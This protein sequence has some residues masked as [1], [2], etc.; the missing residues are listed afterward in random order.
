MCKKLIY[1]VVFTLFIETCIGYLAG[2]PKVRA[3]SNVEIV[4]AP[5]G[6]GNVCEVASPCSLEAGR[7]KVRTLNEDMSSDITVL[8]R[9]G[10]YTLNEPFNLLPGDSGQN[11]Y[12][13]YYRAYP[14]ETPILSGGTVISGWTL[15]DATNNIY[16]APVAASLETRQLYVNGQRA[17]RAKGGALPGAQK[18][19]TGYTTTDMSMKEWE[20]IQDIEFVFRKLWT[21]SRCGVSAIVDGEV[22]MDEPCFQM[23]N[24]TRS[25]Q[26]DNPTWIENAYEL[27]DEEGEWYLD[28][29]GHYLYYIPR[30]GEDMT[31]AEVIAPVLES[32]VIGT[33]TL[34]DPL[35]NVVFEGLT[36]SYATWLQPNGEFGF[37]DIQAGFMSPNEPPPIAYSYTDVK[38]PASVS[39]SGGRNLRFER[40]T[41]IHLGSVGLNVD[42][43]AQDNLIQGNIFKDISGNAMMLGD[44]KQEDY[45]PSVEAR[46][47]DRNTIKNNFITKVGA[48]YHGSVGIWTGYTKNTVVAHNEI[49]DLPYSGISIGW[50]WGE[51]DE[52]GSLNYT[53]PTIVEN[54][55]IANNK[56]WNTMHTLVD[57]AGIY[58][59]SADRNQII[60]GNVISDVHT[61]GAIYLDNNSRYNTVTNNVSFD[62]AGSNHLFFN[63]NKGNTLLSYN[64]WD[65]SAKLYD[66]SKNGVFVSNQVVENP[67]VLPASIINNAGLENAFKD[68]NPPTSPTDTEAPSVPGSLS[69]IEG[70]TA[71]L[72][73]SVSLQWQA[74]S[75]NTAVTGYEILR[76]GIVVGVTTATVFTVR[77]LEPGRAYAFSV[78]ARDAALNLSSLTP[79]LLVTTSNQSNLDNLAYNKK[80]VATYESPEGREAE[81]HIDRNPENAVDGDPLTYAA[82]INEYAWQQ[83][84]DLGS[85]QTFNRVVVMMDPG[86]YASEYDIR[87]SNDGI[88]FTT[89]KSVV[90]F[91]GG[92]SEQIISNTEARYV[93]IVALKPD[94]PGQPG[95]QMVIYELEIYNDLA[96]DPNPSEVNMAL[97]KPARAFYIGGDNVTTKTTGYE[98]I[99]D[100]DL[101]TYAQVPR[102]SVWKAAVDLGFATDF[103][104]IKVSMPLTAYASDFKIE[105]SDNGSTYS[106]VSE[107]AEF[108]GGTYT[109]YSSKNA[110][111]VRVAAVAPVNP[112]DGEQMAIAEIGVYNTDNLSIEQTSQALNDDGTSTTMLQ[113]NE[114]VKANDGDFNTSAISAEQD[115]WHWN[116]NLGTI[117][118]INQI[119]LLV[120]AIPETSDYMDIGISTSVNGIDFIDLEE[121]TAFS[122]GWKTIR[123][124]DRNA[125]Y[126]RISLA[127][128]GA[129]PTAGANLSLNEVE[130]YHENVV[131]IDQRTT[132]SSD[133]DR[134]YYQM[135]SSQAYVFQAGDILE[136]EFMLLSDKAGIGGVDIATSDGKRLK[137]QGD[138]VD[139]WHISGNPASDL[140]AQGQNLWLKRTMKVPSSMQGRTASAWRLAMENDQPLTELQV[141]YKNLLVRN[142]F[143]KVALRINMDGSIPVTG[144]FIQGYELDTSVKSVQLNKR[145]VNLLIGATEALVANVVPAYALNKQVVWTS[146]HPDIA[147][148]DQEGVVTAIQAGSAIVTATTADGGYS[149]QAEV[150]V[151]LYTTSSDNYALNKPAKAYTSGG[152]DSTTHS[153]HEPGKANDGSLETVAVSNMV[154]AWN[155][156]VDLEQVRPINFIQGHMHEASYATEFDIVGS[157]NGETYQLLGHYEN[158]NGGH[159]TLRFPT[160][161]YRYVQ[162]RALKPDGPGQKGDLMFLSE[163]EVYKESPIDPTITPIQASFDKNITKAADLEVSL[164][165]NG[166]TLTSIIKEEEGLERNVDYTINGNVVKLKKEY[167]SGLTGSEVQFSFLFSAGPTRIYT[168]SL[169]DSTPITNPEPNSGSETKPITK[170][171]KDENETPLDGEGKTTSETYPTDVNPGHWAALAVRK[172]INLG[173]VN[174]YSDGTFRP[175]SA[176]TRAEFTTML[177]RSLKL[178]GDAGTPAFKDLSAIPVWARDSVAQAVNMGIIN[179]YSDDS[180]RPSNQITRAEMAV[181]IVKAL[182]L[183]VSEPNN[184]Y[185]SDV[186]HIPMWAKPY[187]SAAYA[188]GLL[189]GRENNLFAPQAEAT[190]AEAVFLILSFLE[191][192]E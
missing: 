15:N 135:V 185:F 87:T 7:D 84:V 38:M 114:A 108:E 139:Q 188:V 125:Q 46:A 110:R 105:V 128:T 40:N 25:V 60:S 39:F 92:T 93:R 137:D 24:N 10:T 131:E 96:G 177:I 66:N 69:L 116:L 127:H 155:W 91:S 30:A 18:T 118:N 43:G 68:L 144:E 191:Y 71:I 16:R 121:I 136:Y 99:V 56:I 103:N 70:D 88:N 80:V 178:T 112:L 53:I 154:F 75:D 189:K 35:E 153:G 78:A 163:V 13:I 49:T 58:S 134:Y 120:S 130:V 180:F 50:G 150:K 17:E 72:D 119:R 182:K 83:Q 29:S 111:Y 173:I 23:V 52:G 168:V 21:E 22:T 36:F 129:S 183:P 67:L 143:G 100:D 148:V 41:F 94:G 47:V 85:L 28:R 140:S 102:A 132:N 2:L 117:K 74:S 6:S 133:T 162:I 147:N 160:Q 104:Q 113:G 86:Y 51:T 90:G 192:K 174:G 146:S 159:F 61:H 171:E 101:T 161:S 63:G 164:F 172:A 3:S 32:L 79:T 165:L 122:G 181:M 170:D 98:A 42:Y 33:G 34:E 20:N 126:V 31:S 76:D 123:F 151:R 5:N 145:S 57:G 166:Q 152:A 27:L 8:L 26:A 37:R 175:S 73:N 14:G 19:E 142:V 138:W 48:E 54:N 186:E 141:K 11:G 157:V 62:I 176:V 12:D 167:L 45:H 77:N 82:S 9:G 64:F 4:V 44:V 187:V 124:E 156:E 65:Q 184:L 115:P 179:G 149:E 89:I 158:F 169:T 95:N 1:L 190:R 59:L 81:M 107:V 106:T 97:N 55:R 109:V